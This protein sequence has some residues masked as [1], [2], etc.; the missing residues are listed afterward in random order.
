MVGGLTTL[1]ILL[2]QIILLFQDSS[3]GQV[4]TVFRRYEGA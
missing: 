3:G 2:G 1:S 4:M